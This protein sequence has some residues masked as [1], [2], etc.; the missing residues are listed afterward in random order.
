MSTPV[1]KLFLVFSFEKKILQYFCADCRLLRTIEHMFCACCL[2]KYYNI[3]YPAIENIIIFLSTLHGL[4][5]DKKRSKS[6]DSLLSTEGFA[7]GAFNGGFIGNFRTLCLSR[8]AILYTAND[9]H[10]QLAPTSSVS[11]GDT[12]SDLILGQ[13]KC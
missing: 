13:V 6:C 2:R 1:L 5:D 12:P 7:M 10:G 4:G 11:I 8:S 3:F 9:L